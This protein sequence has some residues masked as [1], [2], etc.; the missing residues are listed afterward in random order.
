[1]PV[2][3]PPLFAAATGEESTLVLAGQTFARRDDFSPLQL[4]AMQTY[5]GLNTGSTPDDQSAILAGHAY[6]PAPDLTA[7][8][9]AALRS[10]LGITAGSSPTADDASL[11]LAT[12]VFGA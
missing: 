11:I 12:Q 5:L 7:L 8:Q 9:H 2:Y 1:M 4:G 3:Y 10:F 6:R